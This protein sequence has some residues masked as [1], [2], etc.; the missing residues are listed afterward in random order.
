MWFIIYF[1]WLA[2]LK[3]WEKGVSNPASSNRCPGKKKS[4]ICLWIH[5]F[6]HVPL[7]NRMFKFCFLISPL[8]L[9]KIL[10]IQ[11]PFC[12][13]SWKH[14]VNSRNWCFRILPQSSPQSIMSKFPR[15]FAVINLMGMEENKQTE[16]FLT[17]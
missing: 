15:I 6:K 11:E 17:A 16:P 5:N 9:S 13:T 8:L 10:W 7:A 4:I 3:K 2:K 1:S 12:A 14:N